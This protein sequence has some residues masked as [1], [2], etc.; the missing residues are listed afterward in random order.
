MSA[1]NLDRLHAL[2]DSGTF[3]HATYRDQG[4]LWEGLW[5]Y[6]MDESA[7]GYKPAMSFGKHDPDLAAAEAA[8]RHTGISLGSYR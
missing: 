4:T 8:V 3:H 1:T 2:L 5:V 7:I 6:Q